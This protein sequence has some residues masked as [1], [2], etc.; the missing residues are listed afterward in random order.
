MSTNWQR[1]SITI[2]LACLLFFNSVYAYNDKTTHPA[3][4]QEII[5]L[6]NQNFPQAPISLEEA[7]WIIQGSTLEDTPPRWINHFYDPINKS[8][9][10]GRDTGNID[11]EV[12]RQLSLVGL[13]SEK[14]VSALDWVTNYQ[15][16]EKYA[17]YGGNRSWKRGL[18]HYADGDKKEAYITLGHL[19]HI[20]EDMSVPDHTR[21]D[22]HAQV[23]E[24]ITGD[25]GSP[26]ENYATRWNRQN[27]RVANLEGATVP[28][29]PNITEY[30]E[31][32]ASYSNKY[33]FSKDTISDKYPSP[34]PV[35]DAGNLAYGLDENGIKFPIAKISLVKKNGLEMK[36]S[37]VIEKND[38]Q[39]LDAYFSRLSKQAVLNGAGAI[40]LFK[41]QAED[42]LVNKEF[43]T[44]LI[45]L[46]PGIKRFQLPAISLVGIGNKISGAGSSFIATITG[47]FDSED[48]QPIG[49]D[50]TDDPDVT[51]NYQPLAP[52]E[53][54]P[55][56]IVNQPELIALELE[57]IQQEPTIE[58][59][60]IA[61]GIANQ[62]P[63][64]IL[65]EQPLLI[66]TPD[67]I[68][69]PTPSDTANTQGG[70]SHEPPAI[71]P[72][73]IFGSVSFTPPSPEPPPS[74][75]PPTEDDD[76]PLPDDSSDQEEGPPPPSG[77][78]IRNFS[79]SYSSSTMS[80][81]L[82]W[83][84]SADTEST[85][86]YTYQIN[87]LAT[88]G[89]KTLKLESETS[90]SYN[91]LIN[92]EA[93]FEFS[94]TDANGSSTATTTTVSSDFYAHSGTI[95]KQ[96]KKEVHIEPGAGI[97]KP[98]NTV[99]LRAFQT[100]TPQRTGQANQATI[101]WSF[102]QPTITCE[103]RIYR[104]NNP[105]GMSD[106][107]LIATASSGAGCTAQTAGEYSFYFPTS[108]IHAGE[109][110][111]F[112]MEYLID[113]SQPLLWG[114]TDSAPGS[115]WQTNGTSK[116]DQDIYLELLG[117]VM[118]ADIGTGAPS[119]PS[120]LSA[121]FDANNASASISWSA[122]S[123]TDSASSDLV[124][125][126]QA[127]T[128]SA[129]SNSDSD[130]QTIGNVLTTST[131]V[132][133]PNT[134]LIGVRARDEY[135]NYSPVATTTFS[136]PADF[137]PNTILASQTD[138]NQGVVAGSGQNGAT[139]NTFGQTFTVAT[140][141]TPQSLTI[142][143]AWTSGGTCSIRIHQ[144]GSITDSNDSNLIARSDGPDG[145]DCTG[146]N[147]KVFQ[148]ARTN[149]LQP[150]I[151]YIWIYSAMNGS[152]ASDGLIGGYEEEQYPGALR[153]L[154]SFGGE[155]TIGREYNAYFILKGDLQ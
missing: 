29:H 120:D 114:A 74:D 139:T 84:S 58:N 113:H 86:T 70:V 2:L 65:P 41:S 16:Q 62:E 54:P 153:Y 42:A 10:T 66:N 129:L 93:R 140:S 23:V 124:Y 28:N 110:H 4:T 106:E 132:Q 137:D 112:F 75:S 9:W 100:F 154:N 45:D 150:G 149:T 1:A 61:N 19:L 79:S 143:T 72:P 59:D 48:N 131:R 14:P 94:V 147:D 97:L 83:D 22:T 40:R 122:S 50:Q 109:T 141:S 73:P 126:I 68:S 104:T 57:T 18:E 33:F 78:L 35:E 80:A 20:L 87:Q 31:S 71:P 27:L 46:R 55:E 108:T 49:S 116:T 34:R 133:Y 24:Q 89:S 3:L 128:T 102:A 130:W 13:S 44:H 118:S 32:L 92:Q 21:D 12:I 136:F 56:N 15:L 138:A 103:A 64:I 77:P 82:T 39:I 88:D 8:G 115:Y 99:L 81:I 127:T 38:I 47:L 76:P 144:A 17:L 67:T 91:Q 63:E 25:N 53:A 69:K 155:V 98:S 121:T 125:Q 11:A 111:L 145:N 51:A 107:N 43:P 96:E 117:T 90:T 95:F 142:S 148:F 26:Y 151:N 5:R 52:E 36:K 119:A 123:D 30:I 6:Y 134:Y 152:S 60:E 7:E 146:G 101:N 105:D 135:Y 37:Y 85:S